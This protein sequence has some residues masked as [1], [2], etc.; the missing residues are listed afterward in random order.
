MFGEPLLTVGGPFFSQ[1]FTKVKKASP[2]RLATQG[3]DQLKWLMALSLKDNN[4]LREMLAKRKTTEG[5][6]TDKVQA[7]S[8]AV[9]SEG[10]RDLRQSGTPIQAST[11]LAA[12]QN[13]A[14]PMTD[15]IT[16]FLWRTL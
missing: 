4:V 11:V 2:P 12:M 6:G 15:D 13:S 1:F 5:A 16:V 8:G 7:L 10:R 14:F 9:K 3:R